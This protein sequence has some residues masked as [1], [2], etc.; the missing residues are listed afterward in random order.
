[1]LERAGAVGGEGAGFHEL[2]GRSCVRDV[3]VGWDGNKRRRTYVGV[4]SVV[5]AVTCE[6]VLS[7][8]VGFVGFGLAGA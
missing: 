7:A 6:I 5:Y 3:C 8:A 4:V 2:L 1:L